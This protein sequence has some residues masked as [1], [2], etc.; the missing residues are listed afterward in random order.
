MLRSRKII[1]PLLSVFA[2]LGSLPAQAED[3][4]AAERDIR[5]ALETWRAAYNARDAGRVC[6]IFARDVVSSFRRRPDRTYDALCAALR[7]ELQDPS[8][9]LSYRLDI[10]EIMVSGDLA[11]VRLIWMLRNTPRRGRAT[12]TKEPGMD[13]FRREPGGRWRII[14]YLAFSEP[15]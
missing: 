2:A 12:V 13:I 14:R 5:Y 7:R 11:V 1:F 4:A 6:D 9:S 10:N 15:G 8:S 3:K